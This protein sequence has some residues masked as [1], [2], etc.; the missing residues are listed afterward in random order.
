MQF[1]RAKSDVFI[2][3]PSHNQIPV[4]S[5][6]LPLSDPARSIKLSFPET[7]SCSVLAVRFFEFTT[8]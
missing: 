8:I 6:A 4:F 5:V 3:A 2:F 7:I 1:A